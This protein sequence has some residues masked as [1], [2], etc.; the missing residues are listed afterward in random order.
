[1]IT[2]KNY[3]Y[4]FFELI[5]YNLGYIREI[6]KITMCLGKGVL[7]KPLFHP[8]GLPNLENQQILLKEAETRY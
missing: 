3:D 1:M 2:N 7:P 6:H 5:S 8:K 4:Y